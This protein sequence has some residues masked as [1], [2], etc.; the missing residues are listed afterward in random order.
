M[1]A[2]NYVHYRPSTAGAPTACRFEASS[3]TTSTSW[4]MVTCPNCIQVHEKPARRHAPLAGR[5]AYERDRREELSE[6]MY[7]PHPAEY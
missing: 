6:R 7:V 1:N 4:A 2:V 5:A 3:M